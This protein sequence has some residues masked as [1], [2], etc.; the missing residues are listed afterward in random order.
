MLVRFLLLSL[1]PVYIQDFASLVEELKR[2]SSYLFSEEYIV[3]WFSDYVHEDAKFFFFYSIHT[4]VVS[5][6]DKCIV[7]ISP[8]KC[9]KVAGG[10]VQLR[11]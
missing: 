11:Y 10:S 2:D 3:S 5:I 7:D 4:G 6:L 8:S 9:Q 1:R